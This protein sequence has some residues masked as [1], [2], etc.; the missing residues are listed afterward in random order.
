MKELKRWYQYVNGE[1][2]MCIAPIF[3]RVHKNAYVI[4]LS[5]AHR[6]TEPEYMLRQCVR[7]VE[8]FDLGT[9][10]T[11]RL[12]RIAAFIEDG[13]DELVKMPP[14]P[15]EAPRVIGEGEALAGGERITFDVL[16]TMFHGGPN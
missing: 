7:I 12:A 1:P 2:A 16:D 5:A 9:I 10:S 14:E 6:Y 4:C 8:L 13:L 3:V 15:K 11:Q